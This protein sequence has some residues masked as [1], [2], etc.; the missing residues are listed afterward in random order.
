M[1]QL[2]N[3]ADLQTK[4]IEL[5]LHA[6]QKNIARVFGVAGTLSFFTYRSTVT[7]VNEGDNFTPVAGFS[8]VYK[9]L[10]QGQPLGVIVGNTY[11]K[12]A[13]GNVVIGDDGF[14]LADSKPQIIGNPIPDFIV[15]FGNTFRWKKLTLQANW[16]WKKGG[17]TW[18]GTQAALDY[19]GRSA[20]TGAQRD[21][22]NYIFKG[23]QQ[24]GHVNDI[25]VSFYDASLPV[26]NNRWAR[27]GLS[28]VAEAYVQKTDYL[29]LN[30]ISLVYRFNLHRNKQQL[31]LSTYVNNILLWSPYKGADPEQFLFDQPNTAGL[32]FFNLPA[33]KTYGFNVSLQ[34]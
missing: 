16:E 20:T 10:V 14:P 31:T 7:R 32:D 28:G 15:K 4:G 30:N 1:L 19:Y 5:S 29:R 26:E 23:V 8:N 13:S 17:E 6:Y 12:D 22:T 2:K 24:N 11:L 27:Y 3:M 9:A 33:V 18:N 34:F 21:I 25:P